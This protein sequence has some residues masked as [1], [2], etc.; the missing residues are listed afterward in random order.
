MKTNDF[1]KKVEALGFT[2]VTTGYAIRV[3]NQD[4]NT[5]IYVRKDLRLEFDTLWNI[6]ITEELFD[7]AVEY[8]KTPIDEREE[9]KKYYLKHK[10][11]RTDHGFNYLI[12]HI[13]HDSMMLGGA[14]QSDFYKTKFT[15][16]EMERFPKEFNMDEWDL[17]EVTE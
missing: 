12:R 2:T 7:L 4:S 5:L 9:P 15:Y 17:I 14:K 11:L 16:Q 6:G 1:I 10:Y 13:I 3:D 8:A